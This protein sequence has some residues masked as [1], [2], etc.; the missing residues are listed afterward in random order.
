M[1]NTSATGGYLQPT[2]TFLEGQAL[3]NFFH[4]VFVGILGFDNTLV[5]PFYQQNPPTRPSINV[6]WMAFG[7]GNRI[8][9]EYPSQVQSDTEATQN[10]SENIE[11]LCTFY[12]PNCIANAGI[13]RD[14]L[15][16]TQNQESL[17]LNNMALTDV[18]NSRFFAELVND[19]YF[20]RCDMV[21]NITRLIVRTYAILTLQSAGGTI[22]ANEAEQTI[23]ENWET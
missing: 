2:Q 19:Q 22:A 11:I 9:T 7:F 14:S 15:Y 13:L 20:P 5:R 3:L 17:T 23:T 8:V 18:A 21:I 4:D 6:D 12:G 10:A 1:S 16:I